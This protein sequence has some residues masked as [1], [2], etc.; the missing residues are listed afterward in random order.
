MAMMVESLCLIPGSVVIGVRP[1]E[2]LIYAH[3]L[4]V[5]DDAAVAEFRATCAR[6]EASLVRALGRSAAPSSPSARPTGGPG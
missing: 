5:D 3:V 6:W 4:G 1:A 2:G